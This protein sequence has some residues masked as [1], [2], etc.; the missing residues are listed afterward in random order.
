MLG[1]PVPDLSSRVNATSPR[2]TAQDAVRTAAL[3]I[4]VPLPDALKVITQEKS[5]PMK[6][7]L[8][9]GPFSRNVTLGLAYRRMDA[10][11]CRLV[12]KINSLCN[13]SGGKSQ[14]AYSF[15]VDALTG[16]VL[17]RTS[18]VN[19]LKPVRWLVFPDR[20]PRPLIYN[21]GNPYP[22]WVPEL[23]GPE[24][25]DPVSATRR[26]VSTANG[27]AA[28]SPA[29]WITDAAATTSGN[30]AV[31]SLYPGEAESRHGDVG[32]QPQGR[33]TANGTRE[34]IYP[35]NLE[36]RDV[37]WENF[38]D[39][40]ATEAFYW[41]NYLHDYFYDLGFDEPA[42]NFQADNFNKGGRGGDA[43]KVYI[44][45]P[46][47]EDGS[48]TTLEDGESA[49]MHLGFK[50]NRV[51]A[52]EDRRSRVDAT[53]DHQLIAH[54]Y[55]H[56]VT[57][58]MVGG[59]DNIDALFDGFQD[60][61]M[62]EGWSDWFALSILSRNADP[63]D[64][65]YPFSYY[66]CQDISRGLRRY[67]YCTQMEIDPLSYRHVAVRPDLE[68]PAIS[69]NLPDYDPAGAHLIGEIWC[70][71][72]WDLRAEFIQKYGFEAGKR[73]VEQLVFEALAHTDHNTPLRP[74]LVDGRNAILI[75]D[76]LL[77]A[78]NG[79]RSNEGIIWKAFAKRG[80]GYGADDGE[81]DPD[82][83]VESFV[84]PIS[85]IA[86]YTRDDLLVI[87]LYQS[88]LA[89]REVTVN[90]IAELSRDAEQVTLRRDESVREFTAFT[91]LIRLSYDAGQI[92][93][94]LVL[95]V[96]DCDR[97]CVTY[98]DA[99]TRI[100]KTVEL[101]IP[102]E[103]TD[104]YSWGQA[105][106]AREI[107]LVDADGDGR[108]EI[109]VPSYN[110]PVLFIRSERDQSGTLIFTD[111]TDESS[112]RNYADRN[113]QLIRGEET[114]C[115]GDYDDDGDPD[116]LFTKRD[117]DVTLWQNLGEM[118]FRNA[119]IE[120]GL[121]GA[122]T[123]QLPCPAWVDYDLD[124]YLDLFLNSYPRSLFFFNNGDGSFENTSDVV[125]GIG[126]LCASSCWG[127]SNGDGFT[128]LFAGV[129]WGGELFTNAEGGSLI[130]AFMSRENVRFCRWGDYDNDRD[131]DLLISTGGSCRILRNDGNSSFRDVTDEAGL[132][133]RGEYLKGVWVDFD[134]DS[135]LDI[136]IT[137]RAGVWLFGNNGDGTFRE[138]SGKLLLPEPWPA[139]AAIGNLDDDPHPELVI[140]HER[141]LSVFTMGRGG[142]NYLCVRPVIYL[143][144]ETT[145]DAIG[146]RVEVDLD[147]DGNFETGTVMTREI[148]GY[149]QNQMVAHFGLGSSRH[150]GVR[151]SF[152][153]GIIVM[154]R[155][156]PANG[157]VTIVDNHPP[158]FERIPCQRLMPGQRA[159]FTVEA[160]DE[161]GD[162]LTYS[163]VSLP[164]GAWFDEDTREFTWTATS[165]AGSILYTAVFQVTDE[166]G[167]FAE[168]S[169]S[170][171]DCP[172]KHVEEPMYLGNKRFTEKSHYPPP[173]GPKKEMR[174]HVKPEKEPVN[175]KA[176]GK[177]EKPP[178]KDN[179]RKPERP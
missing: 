31:V 87:T 8:D 80:L 75:A 13:L 4:G 137:R 84:N 82:G 58:R 69:P 12:W 85:D 46:E 135:S 64:G 62:A 43:V 140:P 68:Y 67:P 10:K 98:T 19:R 154:K 45:S 106:A 52:G 11:S 138:M 170:M 1:S 3:T 162:E 60:Y 172:E 94:D 57:T 92:A 174:P 59:P 136:V 165:K 97:V 86:A 176:E 177:P 48:M 163:A 110:D 25:Q 139:A 156:V 129:E 128:D 63:L 148:E 88:G 28:A 6:T 103:E 105:R 16:E 159:Q 115:W 179:P 42:G 102:M 37:A 9:R 54:E 120:M 126:R 32:P 81:G 109:F 77:A 18:M 152:P 167:A 121:D 23:P 100:D 71:A 93:R 151:V 95:R 14:Y 153:G 74:T 122:V 83:V 132:L 173:P 17:S 38:S 24:D 107:T 142:N 7:V 40:A 168:M 15:T 131:F 113:G 134:D 33:V 27:G 118:R 70:S 117:Q 125:S 20:S 175:P 160:T 144:G 78:R 111:I 147:D 22:D 171:G 72:L 91:G 44:H 119:T 158:I 66:S 39:A 149:G 157:L 36:P 89:V 130:A 53:Y 2:I 112:I 124:G 61:G 141:G 55:C 99:R 49:V 169:V 90:V 178:R 143:G 47:T 108:S 76:R 146:A 73:K 166:H 116:L 127:D 29:G 114:A 150:V 65:A 34:F 51:L 155:G 5:N 56:G 26:T 133:A 101:C 161:D 123:A 50:S 145:R 79:E 104:G 164:P 35:L 96:R 21:A 30:N 41:A